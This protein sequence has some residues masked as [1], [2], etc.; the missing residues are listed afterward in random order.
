VAHLKHLT[1]PP[2][3]VH[4]R[5]KKWEE[6][7]AW[8]FQEKETSP[9]QV[10]FKEQLLSNRSLC[11]MDRWYRRTYSTIMALAGGRGSSGRPAP[12]PDDPAARYWFDRFTI[13]DARAAEYAERYRSSYMWTILCTTVALFLGAL[14]LGLSFCEKPWLKALLTAMTPF[15][16]LML[17]SVVFIVVMSLRLDWHGRS[18]EYRQLAELF[19]KQE[20]LAALGW[21]LSIGTVQTLADTD[22]LAWVAWLFAATQRA[23]PL[24]QGSILGDGSGRRMLLNLIEEQLAYH[25]GRERIA[26][27]AATTFER[28]GGVAF[29]AVFVC[30]SAE[31]ILETFFRETFFSVDIPLSVL[32][33]AATV[34]PG[35]S[36]AFVTIRSY[37][38]LQLLAEQSHHMILE[39]RSAR[40]RVTRIKPERALASQEIG[41]QAAALATLMLQDLDGWGRLFRGKSMEAL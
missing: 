12:P 6:R 25:E 36:A 4:R 40:T 15:E 38:E 13:V 29:L 23:A 28:F 21:A 39:L 11:L 37:A 31:V 33:F 1:L 8:W 22:R 2:A 20:T 16:W 41:A 3:K 17:G 10:F 30:V 19:R 24:P 5:H 14:S 9:L 18:I 32:R 27:R 26:E 7:L 34:L 35:F